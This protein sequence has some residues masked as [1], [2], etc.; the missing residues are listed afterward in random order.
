MTVQKKY[1]PSIIVCP[2][3]IINDWALNFA[4]M[5][6]SSFIR[7]KL[8]KNLSNIELGKLVKERVTIELSRTLLFSLLYVNFIQIL[9]TNF[10]IALIIQ[11]GLETVVS[12]F[13][14]FGSFCYMDI[15]AGLL[16]FD[17]DS[18][19]RWKEQNRAVGN[20]IGALPN[21]TYLNIKINN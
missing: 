18:F 11:N 3:Q 13:L 17:N 20:N 8:N 6:L 9:L 7:I 21:L 15:L 1:A 12:A 10:R 4:E 5:F 16:H 14:L 19:G 2:G